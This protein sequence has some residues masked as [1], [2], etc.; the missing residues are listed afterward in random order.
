MGIETLSKMH[1]YEEIQKSNQNI[2]HIDGRK[3][4]F[5]EFNGFQDSKRSLW[6][7]Y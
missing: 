4:N 3:Y 2:L 5:E 1:V 6:S 7:I